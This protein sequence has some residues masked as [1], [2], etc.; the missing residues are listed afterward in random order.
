MG[1][2]FLGDNL[3]PDEINIILEG[4]ITAGLTV[5]ANASMTISSTPPGLTGSSVRTPCPSFIDLPAHS[6]PLGLAFFPEE[7]PQEFRYHLLVAFHGSW[8]R[9][10]PTGYK[11]VR[12]QAG[13]RRQFYRRRGLH[14][15]L[16]DPPAPWAARWIF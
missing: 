7:W 8:N 12:Y 15:R 6:A 1:R 4:R 2:D 13:P 9:T 11:V 3:P 10:E 5:T 14:H 16:A